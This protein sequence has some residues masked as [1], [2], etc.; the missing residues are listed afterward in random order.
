[1]GEIEKND[2]TNDAQRKIIAIIAVQTVELQSNV[3]VI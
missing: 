2:V 1:M 3:P